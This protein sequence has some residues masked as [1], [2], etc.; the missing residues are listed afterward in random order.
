MPNETLDATIV[1][2]R[3]FANRWPPGRATSMISITTISV[4]ENSPPYAPANPARVLTWASSVLSARR[5]AI[6]LPSPPPID[7][8]AF[9]GPRLAPPISDTAETAAI[10]GTSPTST[11]PV[12]RSSNRPGV[13]HGSRVRRRTNPTAIP[14][15]TATATHHQCPPNQP[16][17]ESLY[18]L[19]PTVI[20]PTKI[21]AAN[22]PNTPR[23]TAYASRTQNSRFW[24][25]GTVRDCPDAAVTHPPSR[26][27]RGPTSLTAN[28]AAA[29]HSFT[30]DGDDPPAGTDG[31]GERGDS[32]DQ[33]DRRP[34][35]GRGGRPGRAPGPADARRPAARTGLPAAWR[36]AGR[37]RWSRTRCSTRR[38]CGPI[39]SSC[40]NGR[41]P[42]GCP[43]WCRSGTGGC[44]SRR[45]PSTVVP[46]WSWRPT[47]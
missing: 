21:S 28:E 22:A 24:V 15:A 2:A 43:S 9:S 20:R 33:A 38:R 7:P 17:S 3:L 10:P 26:G 46:P 37:S 16:G 45:S 5:R 31:G 40:S 27:R 13:F 36:P 25:T 42:A 8:S 19:P 32:R 44:W 34:D 29:A 35:H 39:R 30:R 41:P 47:W 18:H 6:Q 4:L 12:C 1:A 11:L 14:A 23:T